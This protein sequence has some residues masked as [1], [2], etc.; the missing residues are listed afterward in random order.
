MRYER[1]TLC[2]VTLGVGVEEVTV[3]DI[4]GGYGGLGLVEVYRERGI[5][6]VYSGL[7]IV[8]LSNRVCVPNRGEGGDRY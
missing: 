5:V 2:S 4:V 1:R 3:N 8:E 7:G 6:E